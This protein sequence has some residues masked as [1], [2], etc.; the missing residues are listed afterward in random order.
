MMGRPQRV[1][2]S[3]AS[4]FTASTA[5]SSSPYPSPLSTCVAM[6]RP[7][8]S[9][10]TRTRTIPSISASWALRGYFKK[11]SPLRFGRT[12]GSLQVSAAEAVSD[13]AAFLVTALGLGAAAGP[14]VAATGPPAMGIATPSPPPPSDTPRSANPSAPMSTGGASA[15]GASAATLACDAALGG[16]G[17]GLGFSSGGGGGGGG[18]FGGSFFAFFRSASSMAAFSARFSFGSARVVT[19][20]AAC[21]TRLPP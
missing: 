7:L 18:G 19:A 12:G 9:T 15:F 14:A 2:G 10:V 13:S 20:S 4:F 5:T 6:T 16:G 17:G 3:N 8:S 11:G 1:A 21:S